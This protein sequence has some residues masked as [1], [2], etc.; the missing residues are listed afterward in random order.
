MA[1][2]NRILFH[3]P[4]GMV[5]YHAPEPTE[6][7]KNYRPGIKTVTEAAREVEVI[8]EA[9]VVVVG[10]GP[11]GFAAAICA[12]PGEDSIIH[13]ILFSTQT[14]E[15]TGGFSASALRRFGQRC[16][17]S[18]PSTPLSGNEKSIPYLSAF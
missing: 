14:T 8:R 16:A 3:G 5:R 10:G 1:S 2:S 9:D 11:G 13:L 12:A 7:E 4:N 15:S 6:E 17:A 18:P